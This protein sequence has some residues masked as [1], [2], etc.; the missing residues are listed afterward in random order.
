MNFSKLNKKNFKN[1]KMKFS[2]KNYINLLKVIKK[3]YRFICASNWH[4]YKRNIKYAILRHDIDFD[5]SLALQMAKIE[6]IKNIKANYFFL[7]R[8]DF[9]DLFSIETS[10]NIK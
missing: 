5:T 9:Y 7:L 3:N 2:K 10:K 1:S 8:D 6:K 4:K